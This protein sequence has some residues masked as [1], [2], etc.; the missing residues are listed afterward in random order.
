M[1]LQREVS[2]IQSLAAIAIALVFI[3]CCSLLREPS[4]R[5]LSAVIV[6]GAGAAYLNG[7]LGLWEFAFCALI[8]FLAFRGLND[9]RFIA[10]AWL[11]HA[12]WDLVQHRYGN[13][14]IAVF[15]A[16][17]AGCAIFDVGLA[18][19]YFLGA[20]SVF[21]SFFHQAKHSEAVRE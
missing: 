13:P 16:S 20:P 21:P 8:T 15:P 19:W 3:C 11:L 5:N 2:L 9:Y 17:S 7:G 12:I 4:R 6:A 18:I 14:I 1:P 10:L